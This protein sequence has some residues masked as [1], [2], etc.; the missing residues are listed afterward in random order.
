LLTRRLM[1]DSAKAVEIGSAW[2]RRSPQLGIAA[3]LF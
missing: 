3:A 2:R 1:V